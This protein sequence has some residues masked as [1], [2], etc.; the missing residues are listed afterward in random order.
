[1][2]MPVDDILVKALGWAVTTVLATLLGYLTA[3]MREMSKTDRAM[4]AGMKAIMRR[5]LKIM[6]EQYVIKGRP[7]G[8]DEKDEA[9]E[10][11]SAYHDLGGNGTG[12]RLYEAIMG[13][14][15]TKV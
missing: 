4:H 11:Y 13:L 3:K 14:P 10:I 2:P 9:T 1:M 12:T 7:I 8:V 15:I 5:E 6:H